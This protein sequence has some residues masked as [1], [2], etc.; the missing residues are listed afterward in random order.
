MEPSR[1]FPPIPVNEPSP[2]S[3]N[4]TT[5]RER[6]KVC[7]AKSTHFSGRLPGVPRDEHHDVSLRWRVVREHPPRWRCRR[8]SPRACTCISGNDYQCRRKWK[9]RPLPSRTAAPNVRDR[10]QR[11]ADWRCTELAGAARDSA[12]PPDGAS[13]LTKPSS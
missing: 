3:A 1:Q 8:P 11:H 7:I 2:R 6:I 5:K 9:L 4:V 13:S 10:F 12:P